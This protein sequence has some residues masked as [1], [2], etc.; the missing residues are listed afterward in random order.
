ML[1]QNLNQDEEKILNTYKKINNILFTYFIYFFS[2]IISILFVFYIS[3]YS[4]KKEKQSIVN[5]NMLSLKQ[6]EIKTKINN[7][8]NI[9]QKSYSDHNIEIWIYAWKILFSENNIFSENNLLKYKWYVLPNYSNFEKDIPLNNINMFSWKKYSYNN[10]QVY[11]KNII[12]KQKKSNFSQKVFPL[13]LDKKLKE[14][15]NLD[16]LFQKKNINFTCKYYLNNFLDNFYIF[17]IR[18]DYIW[19][20]KIFDKVKKYDNYRKKLCNNL[21]SYSLYFWK[22]DNFYDDIFFQCWTEYSSK[23]RIFRN[24]STIEK[25]LKIQIL[26]DEVYFK[27]I[28]NEFKLVSFQQLLYSKMQWKNLTDTLINS[29]IFFIQWLFRQDIWNTSNFF[30]DETYY[31]NNYILIPYLQ[32]QKF[33]S[34]EDTNNI[35]SKLFALNKWWNIRFLNW[36]NSMVTY[37]EILKKQSD[38][39]IKYTINFEKTLERIK[40]FVFFT[41]TNYKINWNS[42][43]VEWYFNLENNKNILVKN[44]FEKINWKI[45]LSQVEI[46]KYKK[47]ESFENKNIKNNKVSFTEIYYSINNVFD[48]YTT[49][50]NDISMCDELKLILEDATIYK[51]NNNYIEIAKSRWKTIKYWFTIDNQFNIKN[52]NI[53]DD[54]YR[55][56]ITKKY[57]N[58]ETDIFTLPYRINIIV[59]TKVNTIKK[60]IS[61]W[62]DL[63]INIIETFKLYMWIIPTK[64][65]TKDN[66]AKVDFNLNWIKFESIFDISNSK[67][68]NIIFLNLYVNKWKNLEFKN[69]NLILSNNNLEIINKFIIDPIW[70]LKEKDDTFS[71]LYNKA[72]SQ[73]K[74]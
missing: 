30:K 8:M 67:I 17:N 69:L 18:W 43:S 1:L 71:E 51:C 3:F 23:F 35:I 63:R 70:Y 72:I 39:N 25:Q 12:L 46:P 49:K 44:K 14:K 65:K 32:N 53:S 28:I 41:L 24:F 38:E 37:K 57:S 50:T 31:F 9:Y 56:I 26:S 21:L 66:I 59:N 29:Y 15:F 13:N 60:T 42:M 36:F 45:I 5:K 10:I 74:L 61:K 6:K 4:S 33:I 64:I 58:I 7:Y 68:M 2:A 20:L 62:E 40:S 48:T 19:F 47:L 52:I 34:K 11:V 22:T 55:W 73:N 16:C 27:P 54:I